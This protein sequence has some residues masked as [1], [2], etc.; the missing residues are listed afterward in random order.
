MSSDQNETNGDDSWRDG[1]ATYARIG[2][3]L[4]CSALVV[5]A[6]ALRREIEHFTCQKL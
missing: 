4:T 5:E 2:K 3:I 1:K 6:L